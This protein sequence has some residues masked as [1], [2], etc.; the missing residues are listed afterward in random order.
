[1]PLL[2][3]PPE[4]N[5][6]PPPSLEEENLIELVEVVQNPEQENLIQL[7][8]IIPNPDPI[9]DEGHTNISETDS[10]PSSST[11]LKYIVFLFNLALS[12]PSIYQ[13]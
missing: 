4:I 11:N 9:V 1:M 12:R 3:P 5:F 13:S 6:Q 2:F 7:A 10:L 8:E